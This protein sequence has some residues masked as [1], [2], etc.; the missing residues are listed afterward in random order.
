[1]SQRIK[2]L[3]FAVVLIFLLSVSNIKAATIISISNLASEINLDAGTSVDLY[4]ECSGCGDSY[5]RGVFYPSG[6]NYFG[7]TQNNLGEWIGTDPDRGHYFKVAKEELVQASWSGQV[8]IKPV[9]DSAFSGTG[10]YFFKLGRYTSSGDSSADWSNELA[11]RIVGPTPSP[12]QAPTK[13]PTSAPINSPTPTKSPIPTSTPTLKPTLKPTPSPEVLGIGDEL[14][15]DKPDPTPTEE[16]KVEKEKKPILIP[17]ILIG[18]GLAMIGFVAVQ[19]IRAK[20][21]SQEV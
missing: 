6:T 8:K 16:A 1:M 20:K 5:F 12:T 11:V 17:T 19:L 2:T 10:E 7:Q 14:K 21:I 3:V 18:S 13:E 15:T 4:F 9:S